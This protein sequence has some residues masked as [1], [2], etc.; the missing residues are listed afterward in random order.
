M[1]NPH[2]NSNSSTSS[3]SP[4][5]LHLCPKRASARSRYSANAP[6]SRAAS[7][8]FGSMAADV[9]ASCRSAIHAPRSAAPASTA[10]ACSAA[11]SAADSGSN[12]HATRAPNTSATV[13]RQSG[14]RAPPPT[15]RTS[16]MR[17]GSP[18]RCI[19][20]MAAWYRRGEGGG[21]A[22]TADVVHRGGEVKASRPPGAQ[23]WPLQVRRGRAAQGAPSGP[24]AARPARRSREASLASARPR[25]KGRN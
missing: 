10:A 23:T 1:L 22:R 6:S 16:S 8:A 5:T 18:C 11:P 20:P 15:S 17:S 3:G 25:G 12:G 21:S 2:K 13:W 24:L 19:T 9:G 7:S 14:D 4:A